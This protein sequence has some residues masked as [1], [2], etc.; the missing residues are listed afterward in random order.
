MKIEDIIFI[1]V[2][3]IFIIAIFFGLIAIY[4]IYVN[5]KVGLWHR[6]SGKIIAS[7]LTKKESNLYVDDEDFVLDK[8]T[9]FKLNLKY[10]YEYKGQENESNK[11]YASK[12]YNL[13]STNRNSKKLYNSYKKGDIIEV[14]VDPNKKNSSVLINKMQLT[15]PIVYCIVLLSLALALFLFF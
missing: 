9:V 2:C 5:N 10:S 14:Y 3:L 12:L 1:I 15:Y 11:I 4:F 6:T 8:E 13:F 7:D